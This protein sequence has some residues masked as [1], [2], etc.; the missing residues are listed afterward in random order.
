MNDL[1]RQKL[2]EIIQTYG[3]SLCDDPRRC[4]ALLRDFCPEYRGDIFVLVNALKQRVA[5]DLLTRSESVPLK[6]LLARL[7]KRLQDEFDSSEEAARWAVESWALVLGAL[8]SEETQENLKPSHGRATD[9]LTSSL[10]VRSPS[11]VTQGSPAATTVSIAQPR[12]GYRTVVGIVI[13]LALIV[14]V[15][16]SKWGGE[17]EELRRLKAEMA[18][19]EAA[20]RKAE[21]AAHLEAEQ[22]QR[23]DAARQAQ[24][25]VLAAEEERRLV[26]RKLQEEE[27]RRRAEQEQRQ[28]ALRLQQE[29]E[30]RR[31][32]EE[33]ARLEAQ[34]RQQEKAAHQAQLTALA[35]AT[36]KGQT[37]VVVK[38]ER[39]ED[40]L[41]GWYQ[42]VRD[43]PIRQKP[44]TNAAVLFHLPY[45]KKIKV[46][47]IE[48]NFV[49]VES[50][51][52]RSAGYV[53]RRD[54]EPFAGE[55]E[56]GRVEEESGTE[57]AREEKY[58]RDREE[59]IRQQKAARPT[60]GQQREAERQRQEALRQQQK[61]LRDGERIL[62]GLIRR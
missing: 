53:L 62:K 6:V 9:S 59:A 49:R 5:A 37:S 3:R 21:E 25:A 34:Q 46:V 47:G 43:T 19:V 29:E 61:L 24:L 40:I 12:P 60:A 30:A 51:Q 4:E 13:A 31:K 15:F 44:R 35:A 1:P 22:R 20:R 7:T 54:I 45:G 58:I 16:F 18:L 32:A 17:E 26:E 52:G 27:T 8:G 38:P 2:R 55:V 50:T 57:E 28:L 10:S 42:T 11:S 33:T 23:E 41:L 36:K 48:G 39:R 56:A 14:V